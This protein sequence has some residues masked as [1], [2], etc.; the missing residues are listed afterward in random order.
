MFCEIFFTYWAVRIV[1]D[2]LLDSGVNETDITVPC[3]C[4]FCSGLHILN[5]API[6]HHKYL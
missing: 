5:G 2:I 4:S 3:K 1:F 6:D